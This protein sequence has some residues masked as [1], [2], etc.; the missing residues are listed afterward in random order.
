MRS[1]F[2]SLLLLIV[3]APAAAYAATIRIEQQGPS[4]EPI[5]GGCYEAYNDDY[6]VA[7][8]DYP[9]DDDPGVILLPDVGSGTYDVE[10]YSR[11]PATTPRATSP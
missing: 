4:G 7:R 5:R 11:R 2:L 9:D 1:L 6:S 8:C 3:A 10:E